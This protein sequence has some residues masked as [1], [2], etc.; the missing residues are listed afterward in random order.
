LRGGVEEE[1]RAPIAAFSDQIINPENE[2]RRM[3]DSIAA[4]AAAMNKR[5][6]FDRPVDVAGAGAGEGET[7]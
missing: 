5:M 6:S 1:V 4:D 3:Q 7:S 2:R